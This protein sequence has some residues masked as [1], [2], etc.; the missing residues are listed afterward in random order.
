MNL[1]ALSFWRNSAVFAGVFAR[2]GAV[3]FRL[4]DCV[5]SVSYTPLAVGQGV[6]G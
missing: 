1:A 6:R 3:G 2:V 4:L 5:T